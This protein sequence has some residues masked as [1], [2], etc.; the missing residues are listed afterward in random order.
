MTLTW[1]LATEEVGEPVS[2]FILAL[3]QPLSNVS[4]ALS[5][6]H[7]TPHKA[8]TL[9]AAHNTPYINLLYMQI[10]IIG[11][12]TMPKLAYT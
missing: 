2:E 5:T 9:S 11:G 3:H 4:V 6:A 12:L 10:I 7:N 1:F 8:L